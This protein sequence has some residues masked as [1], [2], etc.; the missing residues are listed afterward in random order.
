MFLCVSDSQI[1]GREVS[2]SQIFVF[3][4]TVSIKTMIK[5][6]ISL[7]MKDS[8]L[9]NNYVGVTSRVLK[10]MIIR[11]GVTFWDS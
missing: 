5:V 7:K 8:S 6:F 10:S 11:H 9:S 2:E 1:F 3:W 4:P